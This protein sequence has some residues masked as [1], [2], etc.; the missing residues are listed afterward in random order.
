MTSKIAIAQC[1]ITIIII[2]LVCVV[3]RLL[4]SLPSPPPPFPFLPIENEDLPMDA[5]YH[6]PPLPTPF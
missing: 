1:C 4:P 2:I 6:S 5:F 3:L